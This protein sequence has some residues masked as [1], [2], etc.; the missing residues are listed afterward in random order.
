[1]EPHTGIP[2]GLLRLSVGIEDIEDLKADLL[3]ALEN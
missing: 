1:I 3:D 2:E